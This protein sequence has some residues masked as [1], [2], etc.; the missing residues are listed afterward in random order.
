M[1]AQR[2]ARC[3]MVVRGA[4]RVVRLGSAT[5]VA[6]GRV[7]GCSTA[8]ACGQCQR[9]NVASIASRRVGL[10]GLVGDLVEPPIAHPFHREARINHANGV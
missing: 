7:A 6:Y 8:Y 1:L 10:A 2:S 9:V 3:R 4:G 5:V